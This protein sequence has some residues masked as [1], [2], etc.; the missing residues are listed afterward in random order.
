VVN[1]LPERTRKQPACPRSPWSSLHVIFSNETER[2]KLNPEWRAKRVNGITILQ[3]REIYK[4]RSCSWSMSIFSVNRCRMSVDQNLTDFT[5]IRQYPYPYSAAPVTVQLF[6]VLLVNILPP[7]VSIFFR[8]VIQYSVH[9]LSNIFP[10]NNLQRSSAVLLPTFC[11]TEI[12]LLPSTCLIFCRPSLTRCRL[13][14]DIL[15]SRCPIFCRPPVQ[16][17]FIQYFS[18]FLSNIR[19]SSRPIFC[20]WSPVQ[21]LPSNLLQ[22]CF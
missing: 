12:L 11:R 7:P 2:A 10:V 6:A 20:C 5:L 8:P 16:C 18:V 9:L 4:S 3:S 22:D 13:L 17:V 19:S 21:N 14:L 1:Q 15:P